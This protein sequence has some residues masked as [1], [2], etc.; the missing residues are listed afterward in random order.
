MG[1]T[2]NLT[3]HS[4]ILYKAPFDNG[5]TEHEFDHIFTGIYEGVILPD[6]EEVEDYKHISIIDL[7][8]EIETSPQNFTAWFKLLI[9]SIVSEI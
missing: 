9:P 1:F 3:V 6:P 2:T 5:L 8:K 4:T 7:K